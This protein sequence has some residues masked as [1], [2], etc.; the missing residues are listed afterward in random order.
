MLVIGGHPVA[1]RSNHVFIKDE[2]LLDVLCVSDFRVVDIHTEG[3]ICTFDRSKT[4]AESELCNET[5]RP[6]LLLETFWC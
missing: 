6:G 1:V 5:A 2:L 4:V 3:A